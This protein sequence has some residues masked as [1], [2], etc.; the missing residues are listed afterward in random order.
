MEEECFMVMNKHDILPGK[1]VFSD[2][3]IHFENGHF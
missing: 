1:C 3:N 2:L